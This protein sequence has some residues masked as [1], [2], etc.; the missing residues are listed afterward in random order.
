MAGKNIGK[1]PGEQVTDASVQNVTLNFG[2]LR[3]FLDGLQDRAFNK[4]AKT[5]NPIIKETAGLLRQ[6]LDSVAE[7]SGSEIGQ[8]LPQLNKQMSSV[9]DDY[10]KARGMIGSSDKIMRAYVGKPGERATMVQDFMGSLDQ[11]YGTTLAK[12]FDRGAAQQVFEEIYK[13][14]PAKGSSRVNAFMVGETAKGIASG[15]GTGAFAGTVIPGVGTGT[16]AVVGGL[17]G[18]ARAAKNAA[19]LAQPEKGL[20]ALGGMLEQQAARNAMDPTKLAIRDALTAGTGAGALSQVASVQG[21][22]PEEI[23]PFA[24]FGQ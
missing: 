4:T 13:G 11:K 19:V 7:R 6:E 2:Q 24:A 8:L 23:D 22:E 9:L 20:Q 10:E 16:G 12:D 1:K 14:A 18:G 3:N 15:A 17:I 5:S 21:N